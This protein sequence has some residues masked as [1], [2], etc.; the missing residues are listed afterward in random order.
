MAEWIHGWLS[1]AP[2]LE[3]VNLSGLIVMVLG[4]V[5]AIVGG[6]RFRGE[7]NR[8]KSLTA[9]LIGLPLAAI[10]ALIAIYR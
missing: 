3:R 5:V 7:E 6:I 2:G 10:G 1:E 8:N 9:R 4:V